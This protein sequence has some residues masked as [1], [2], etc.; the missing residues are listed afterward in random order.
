V[1]LELPF[2]SAAPAREWSAQQRAIFAAVASEQGHLQIV[3]RAGTG[4]TTTIIEALSHVPRGQRVLLCAFNKSIADELTSRAPRGVKVSTLHGLGFGAVLRRWPSISKTPDKT[5][6]RRLMERALEGRGLRRDLAPELAKVA[7]LCKARLDTDE[8]SI[9]RALRSAEVTLAPKDHAAC[10]AAIVDAVALATECDGTISFDDMVFVPAALGWSCGT[11]D[12]VFVDE[13]QD[14]SAAQLQLARSALAPGG[15]MVLVGDDR[16][17]IYGW[18]GADVGGM[19]RMREE[20]EANTLPLSITYRCGQ[21]I[22]LLAAQLVPDFQ[23]APSNPAGTIRRGTV[24]EAREGDAV[25]SRINAP[26]VRLALEAIR[27]GKRARIQG[28]DIGA[29]LR[30]H[31]QSFGEFDVR[32]LLR[33]AKI[34]L[35][36]SLADLADTEE[37]EEIERLQDQFATLTALCEDARTINDV[38]A[39]IERLFSD[40]GPGLI[41]SSTHRAK[42]LEWNRV[43]LLADTYRPSASIEG[44]NLWYV[45]VTRAR[46][47][48]VLVQIGKTLDPIVASALGVA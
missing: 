25:L 45:A 1:T 10:V 40:D 5:R 33:S 8:A 38:L 36:A 27:A 44:E 35:E 48:L 23:A 42:G 14:M 6:D 21:R 9:L 3:A 26:L 28:R 16:Q 15:R 43:F 30:A 19:A 34:R 22:A 11:Y 4:K 32:A 12:L 24:D 41:F 31:A 46:H 7:S 37:G 39:R 18:R 2:L 17:A 47:E 20:L 13:T 29:G